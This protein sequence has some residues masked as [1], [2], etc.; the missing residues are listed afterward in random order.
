[1]DHS[2]RTRTGTELAGDH[3]GLGLRC[4]DGPHNSVDRSTDDYAL[5]AWFLA[6]TNRGETERK[7]KHL[8]SQRFDFEWNCQQSVHPCE[9]FGPGFHFRFGI[10]ETQAR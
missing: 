3:Y 7:T 1:M 10:A 8:E 4:Y 6:D 5:S 9:P 2:L